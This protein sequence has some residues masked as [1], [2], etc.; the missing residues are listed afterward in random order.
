MKHKQ[1]QTQ[2]S[3]YLD[4]QLS[5]QELKQVETHLRT[6]NECAEILSDLSR[7]ARWMVDLRQPAPLGIWEG[8]HTQIA[9]ESQ[10]ERKRDWYRSIFRPIPV[11]AMALATC[12]LLALVYLRPSPQPV[13]NP[14][15]IYLT[16]HTEYTDN[17]LPSD[18]SLDLL[19]TE[20]EPDS[21]FSDDTNTSLDA[22]LDAYLG[23]ETE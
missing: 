18:F 21:L 17:L 12:L 8:I 1:I 7:N 22:Y 6:C 3:A 19:A 2:L 16:A 23:D 13:E 9:T 15:D 4:D 11:G 14:L 10:D 5:R 20:E